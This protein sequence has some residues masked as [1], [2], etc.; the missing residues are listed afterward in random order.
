MRIE[1][2]NAQRRFVQYLDSLLMFG[3]RRSLQWE[4]A[5]ATI[6]LAVVVILGAMSP[7]LGSVRMAARYRMLA[8]AIIQ[9]IRAAMD[10]DSHVHDLFMN[11]QCIPD[12]R[13]R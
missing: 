5:T 4:M 13:C 7:A 3:L 11:A 6:V 2:L 1:W 12:L 8:R 9:S 10:F